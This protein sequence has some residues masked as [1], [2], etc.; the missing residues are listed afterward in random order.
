VNLLGGCRVFVSTEVQAV[1]DTLSKDHSLACRFAICLTT[2]HGLRIALSG[3]AQRQIFK[4][5]L[6]ETH[7]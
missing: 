6:F 3:P 7:L 1:L 2:E 5:S 4:F